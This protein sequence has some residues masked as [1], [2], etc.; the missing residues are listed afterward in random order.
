MTDGERKKEEAGMGR[1]GRLIYRRGRKIGTTGRKKRGGER[2]EE[3]KRKGDNRE[4]LE[5]EK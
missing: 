2:E 5:N 3:R 1:E 4:E